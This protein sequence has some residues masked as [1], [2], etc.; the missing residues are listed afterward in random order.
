MF[1]Y[2][3]PQHLDDTI[4]AIT[5]GQYQDMYDCDFHDFTTGNIRQDEKI[6]LMNE[7]KK[8]TA[9]IGKKSILKNVDLRSKVEP[10]F[11]GIYTTKH[12]VY[13]SYI[14]ECWVEAMRLPKHERKSMIKVPR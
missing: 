6:E 7:L 8:K 14:K 1:K 4:G 2:G 5:H 12:F 13:G 10:H 9:E 3:C 11:D